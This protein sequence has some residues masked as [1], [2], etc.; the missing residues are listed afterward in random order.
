M[1]ATANTVDV[2]RMSPS[3]IMPTSADVVDRTA[4]R[5]SMP[6][7]TNW[8]PN[9]SSPTGRRAMLTYL[10]MPFTLVMI[11]ELTALCCLAS[12]VMRAA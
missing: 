7:S 1:T 4:E 11:S 6:C 12:A 9:S 3:G 5:H 2:N 10:M 8:L